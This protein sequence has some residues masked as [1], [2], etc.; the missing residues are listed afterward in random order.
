MAFAAVAV[1]ISAS[2]DRPLDRSA[3][4]HA[5]PAPETVTV[6]P[7]AT[8]PP[9][10]LT[11]ATSSS[12]A[13]TPK[14]RVVCLPFPVAITVC[15]TVGDDPL[16]AAA[17]IA[18]RCGATVTGASNTSPAAKAAIRVRATSPPHPDRYPP[19]GMGH[20]TRGPP[21]RKTALPGVKRRRRIDGYSRGRAIG[22]CRRI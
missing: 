13:A 11:N 22:P 21:K 19:S 8:V 6:C 20:G 18:A 5:S 7:L 14:A 17:V 10:E 1:Q 3:S 15:F 2:P 16:A 9:P 4:D 12:L